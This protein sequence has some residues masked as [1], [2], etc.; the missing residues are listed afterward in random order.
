MTG[1]SEEGRRV[2]TR[3]GKATLESIRHRKSHL[4]VDTSHYILVYKWLVCVH[5]GNS[6]V[7]IDP[8]LYPSLSLSFSRDIRVWFFTLDDLLVDVG[9]VL[10][11]VQNHNRPYLTKLC[12]LGAGRS[13]HRIYSVWLSLDHYHPNHIA[14]RSRKL[15]INITIY[16]AEGSIVLRCATSP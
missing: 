10:W 16:H 12:I 8:L 2:L 4:L 6:V 14:G 11:L 9:L 7:S 3:G 13:A 5:A 1:R 15:L